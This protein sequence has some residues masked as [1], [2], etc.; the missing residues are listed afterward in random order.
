MQV[1]SMI[2]ILDIHYFDQTSFNDLNKNRH[3]LIKSTADV[4]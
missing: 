3:F 4:T 2:T 1:K